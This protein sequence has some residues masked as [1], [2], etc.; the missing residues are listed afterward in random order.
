MS[1][2][3][4]RCESYTHM[5]I[6]EDEKVANTEN[7]NVYTKQWEI[8]VCVW[9]VNFVECGTVTGTSQTLFCYTLRNF[10]ECLLHNFRDKSKFSA[11]ISLYRGENLPDFSGNPDCF[12][13]MLLGLGIHQNM[14]K[15]GKAVGVGVRGPSDN[16]VWL[17]I[18][19][20][21]RV[22]PLGGQS[23]TRYY[24]IF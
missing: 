11:F 15:N 20:F 12:R 7:L 19:A 3:P 18:S 23:L 2:I 21:L 8:Y 13:T 17:G 24:V 14:Q 16:K 6:N 9:N 22:G 4:A 5:I 10:F 1:E